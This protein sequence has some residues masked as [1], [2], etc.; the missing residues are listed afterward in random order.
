MG[1]GVARH[2]NGV[3][4]ELHHGVDVGAEG[5]GQSGRLLSQAL[6]EGGPQVDRHAQGFLVALDEDV[7]E[8]EAENPAIQPSVGGLAAEAHKGHES[9]EDG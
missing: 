3:E 2:A 1:M 5:G 9:L 4:G 8:Y 6:D 7:L